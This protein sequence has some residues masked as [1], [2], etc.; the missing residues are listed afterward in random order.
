MDSRKICLGLLLA[1]IGGPFGHSRCMIAQT[2]IASPEPLVFDAATIKLNPAPEKTPNIQFTADGFAARSVT[3]R[4]VIRQAFGVFDSSLYAG[5]PSWIDEK[6][7]DIQAKFDPNKYPSMKIE[8]RRAMLL[9]L[10]EDRFHFV[11]HHEM[12]NYPLYAL[13]VAHDGPKFQEAKSDDIANH[14]TL[15]TIC[16]SG[17]RIVPGER[18]F[19]GCTMEDFARSLTSLASAELQKTVVDRTG[20]QGRYSFVLRWTPETNTAANAVDTGAPYIREALDKE[21]GL[22]LKSITGPLDTI[23]IDRVEMPTEN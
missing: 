17:N 7:F 13:V 21:L 2:A 1:A 4:L 12:R 9:R 15:G 5:G 23:V 18:P 20:L 22:E 10:L 3:L 6:T 16:T 11:A 19:H 14:P 8:Q